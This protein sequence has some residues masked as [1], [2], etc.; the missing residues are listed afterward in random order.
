M[1][2]KEFQAPHALLYGVYAHGLQDRKTGIYQ[3]KI[4]YI[5]M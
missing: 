4:I 5:D 3:M 1:Y 2:L